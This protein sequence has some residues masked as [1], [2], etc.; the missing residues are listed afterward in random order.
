MQTQNRI[1]VFYDN[2]CVDGSAS[3]WVLHKA[4]SEEQIS[5]AE[6]VALGYGNPVERTQ[7]ILSHLSDGAETY[8]LDTSP[9]DDTLGILFGSCATRQ[10][11]KKLTVIDHHASE[12]LRLKAFE[13]KWKTRERCGEGEPE[14]V[15]ILDSSKSAA[16]LLTWGHFF[17]SRPVPEL[18]YW[19]GRMETYGQLKTDDDYAIAAYIDLKHTE[20]PHEIL[21]AMDELSRTPKTTMLGFGRVLYEAQIKNIEVIR[22]HVNYA[23]VEVS[24]G[25]WEW[26][27]LFEVDIRLMGRAMD[28][29][30]H[31]VA[32]ASGSGIAGTYCT[33]GDG[34]VKLSLRTNGLPDAGKI[35]CFVGKKIGAGGGGHSTSAVVQFRDTD[36]FRQSIV[37]YTAEQRV[38]AN[39]EPKNNMEGEETVLKEKPSKPI[40]KRICRRYVRLRNRYPAPVRAGTARPLNP[41][42][43][44]SPKVA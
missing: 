1:V 22:P 44:Q 32:Q 21:P 24:E 31:E 2:P 28:R 40:R 13:E 30:L 4:F 20:K 19:V 29:L 33:Q 43:P 25:R 23:R 27:G 5:G 39:W 9:K 26:I 8:F 36:E 17:P 16:A 37:L 41:L 3:L 12:V 10:K 18:L 6:Y 38:V 11:I 14:F 35:A 34:T 15:S 7:K 42:M